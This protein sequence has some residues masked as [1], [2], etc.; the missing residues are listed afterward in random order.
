M[1]ANI[2]ARNK[3]AVLLT[4]EALSSDRSRY[5]SLSQGD[6]CQ[7]LEMTGTMGRNMKPRGKFSRSPI[8]R[9]RART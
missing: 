8:E 7:H 6:Q 9:Q 5:R 4:C 2:D 3:R 1:L